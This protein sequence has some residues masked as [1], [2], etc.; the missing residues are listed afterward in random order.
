MAIEK[1]LSDSISV[2]SLKNSIQMIKVNVQI[3]EKSILEDIYLI[4]MVI[5]A[6]VNVLLIIYIFI[7]NRKKDDNHN[8]KNRKIDL[9]KTLIL[10]CNI[11]KLYVFFKNIKEN[12]ME[13]NNQS[14]SI[15]Q[16]GRIN[17]K[18][19]DLATAYRQD[20]IDLFLAVDQTLYD[21]ILE[22][23]DS[24]IDELTNTIFDEGINLSHKPKFDE[25]V[26][27]KIRESKTEIIKVL[28][29]Y[30]GV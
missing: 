13:L 9:L 7:K 6:T 22:K 21:K 2:D 16:K 1:L 4:A 12:A 26:I 8:E 5:I 15:E 14:L 24:L 27:K 30:S 17:D 25:V 18:L 19:S 29:S 20:F 23:T 11:E 10:N 28:F 3:P